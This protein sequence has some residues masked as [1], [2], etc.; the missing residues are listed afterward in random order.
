MSKIKTFDLK[1]LE[2]TKFIK[3]IEL[4]NSQ[5]WYLA[6]DVL[7]EIWHETN[8]PERTT[9]QGLLQIAVAQLHLSRGNINGATILYGEALGR[10]RK[11]A[12]TDL[13]LDID[14]LCQNIQERLSLLQQGLTPEKLI[15]PVLLP[16]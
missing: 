3:A 13:G 8:F 16:K 4:F 5:E 6:H 15:A 10:L 12:M 14:F 7:E 11:N 9:V 1:S 2:E